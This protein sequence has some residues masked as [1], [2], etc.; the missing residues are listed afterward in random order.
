MVVNLTVKQMSKSTGVMN[1]SRKLSLDSTVRVA[2]DQASCELVG[3]AV[4]LDLNSG[5]Y[6]GL[7]SVGARIWTLLEQPTTV[8]ALRDAAVAEYDIEPDQCA[9]ELLVFLEQ[10]EAK[11]L[12]EVT[13]ETAN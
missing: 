8:K 6:Y 5:V 4:I 1:G 2:P 13:D 10:L 9:D 12:I 11:R 7:D 3:E